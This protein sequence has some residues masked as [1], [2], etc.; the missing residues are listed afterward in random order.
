MQFKFHF[1]KKWVMLQLGMEIIPLNT[2]G[3]IHNSFSTLKRQLMSLRPIHSEEPGQKESFVNQ[4]T[5]TEFFA[6]RNQWG[7]QNE[8]YRRLFNTY[9]IDCS[10]EA[11]KKKHLW[12]V[13]SAHL[14]VKRKSKTKHW[15]KQIYSSISKFQMCLKNCSTHSRPH[16]QRFTNLDQKAKI[17]LRMGILS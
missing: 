8:D 2:S 12:I 14:E 16:C 17:V 4:T 9:C 7:Q 11:K 6:V 5:H 10:D 3:S 15:R 1:F 13:K